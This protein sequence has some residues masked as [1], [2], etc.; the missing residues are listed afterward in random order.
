MKNSSEIAN[1]DIK[2]VISLIHKACAEAHADFY[3]IG[4]RAKDFWFTANQLEPRRYTMDIDFAV[5]VPSMKVFEKIIELLSVKYGFKTFE[6]IP[7]RIIFTKS[8]LIIDILPFGGVDKAGYIN[9][10]DKFDTKISV[11]GFREVYENAVTANFFGEE[12][13]VA[14]LPGLCILKLIAWSDNPLERGKDIQDISNIIQHFFNIESE[15]IYNEHPD[16]FEND[17]FDMVNAGARVLGRQINKILSGSAKTK[18]RIVSILESNVK[19]V[20][21]SKIGAIIAKDSGVTIE[22]AVLLLKELLKG[23]ND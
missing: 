13:K 6:K 21:H 7:H 15:V 4:A 3:L 20:E 23:I 1:K 10:S 11:L 19:D 2:E 5:L 17:D 14:S 12:I 8:D 22:K 16:L 9:F 18:K